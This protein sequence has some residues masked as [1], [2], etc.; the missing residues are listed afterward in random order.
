MFKKFLLWISFFLWYIGSFYM[1]V[2]AWVIPWTIQKVT[3]TESNTC[4]SASHL[5][6]PISASCVNTTCNTYNTALDSTTNCTICGIKTAAVDEVTEVVDASGFVTIPHTAAVP[7]VCFSCADSTFWCDI[8]NTTWSAWWGTSYWDYTLNESYPSFGSYT[9]VPSWYTQLTNDTSET[10]HIKS[11]G[12]N[13]TVATLTWW[14][15]TCGSSNIS[16][17]TGWSNGS[18]NY[19]YSTDNLISSFDQLWAI[20]RS[21]PSDDYTNSECNVDWRIATLDTTGPTVTINGAWASVFNTSDDPRCNITRYRTTTPTDYIP[22]SNSGCEFYKTKNTA[23]TTGNTDFLTWLTIAVSD[24]ESGISKLEIQL[25]SCNYNT[26]TNSLATILVSTSAASWVKAIYKSI[27]LSY[28]DLKTWFWKTRLDQCLVAWKNKLTVYV[29][30]Q[31]R[32]I[33]DG[34]SLSVNNTT[35]V[36]PWYINIDN[37][38]PILKPIDDLSTVHSASYTKWR[39]YTLKGNIQAW[40][41]YNTL[42]SWRVWNTCEPLISTGATCT[43]LPS[44]SH[45]IKPSW[46]DAITGDFTQ[47]KCSLAS[48]YAPTLLECEYGSGTYSPTTPVPPVVPP[49]TTTNICT[50][51]GT[52]PCIVDMWTTPTIPITPLGAGECPVWQWF[53]GTTCIPATKCTISLESITLAT[54]AWVQIWACKNVWATDVW[55]GDPEVNETTTLWQPS[56]SAQWR[57]WNFYQWWNDTPIATNTTITT[58]LALPT[59]WDKWVWSGSTDTTNDWWQWPCDSG[60]HVPTKDEWVAISNAVGSVS[61]I[62]STLKLPYATTIDYEWYRNAWTDFW[63]AT[64]N[65]TYWSA[66]PSPFWTITNHSSAFTYS[67]TDRLW[68]YAFNMFTTDGTNYY[69]NATDLWDTIYRAR[70]FPIRC[71]KWEPAARCAPQPTYVHASYT[72]WTPTNLTA[73]NQLSLPCKYT[74]T[75]GYTGSQCDIPPECNAWQWFNWT[76]CVSATGCTSWLES[77]TVNAYG[78]KQTWACK[79]VWATAVWDGTPENN[80]TSYS[81]WRDSLTSTEYWNWR[82]NFYQWWND[83]PIATIW[84]IA[85][86]SPVPESTNNRVWAG[87]TDTTNVWWQ[88]PCDSGWHVPTRTD[89]WN[90]YN[91]FP[92]HDDFSRILKLPH[93]TTIDYREYRNNL[94][95]GWFFF[96]TN[97]GTYWTGTPTWILTNPPTSQNYSWTDRLWAYVVNMYL[98][99]DTDAIYDDV[100]YQDYGETIFRGRGFPVRCI[101]NWTPSGSTFSCDTQPTYTHAIF[102]IG[103]PT[104]VNQSWVK[105]AVNCWYTCKDRYTGTQCEIL[106]V[107]LPW[108]WFNWTRCISATDCGVSWLESLTVNANGVT[109]TWAC[110][111]LWAT[112]VWDGTPENNVTNY[113]TWATSLTTAEYWNWRW[114]FYQWW[115]NTPIATIWGG[116]V[117]SSPLPDTTNNRVWG[118]SSSIT[119]WWQWPCGSGWHVPTTTDWWNY[120]T[121]FRSTFTGTL[122]LPIATTID[123]QG[124]RNNNA[125]GWFQF[126]TNNGTYWTGTPVNPPLITNPINTQNYSWTDRLRSYALNIFLTG[127]SDTIY[128]ITFQDYGETIYRGRGFPIRCIKD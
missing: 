25:W 104:S 82:W 77:L 123:Y 27:A 78:V 17:R 16:R 1:I 30:D 5:Y 31:A 71:I 28:D 10:C 3:Y 49:T 103:T 125:P 8:W 67:L 106:P 107:C 33:A 105:W 87:S 60:W 21:L 55:N 86:S 32:S 97:N 126:A 81:V 45:W 36:F 34:I 84:G 20:S 128:D 83:T 90:Y 41:R 112:A 114:N 15:T 118:G 50:A 88:W 57:R 64:I 53:D 115:N 43:G 120:R 95:P 48:S 116:I 74:C 121:T 63:F 26:G 14:P 37:L 47:Y 91:Q 22:T 18:C 113:N 6:T 40:E 70:W 2:Y 54:S 65:G 35:T 19:S 12:T 59:V 9:P 66:T 119:D 108:E 85:P 38:E 102:E 44:N 93:A 109:Q 124:Y 46:V 92:L 24:T 79:N 39:N 111:N 13:H 11:N 80:S 73:R 61:N 51:W 68:A 98:T 99:G 110:K 117:A 4:N 72:K 56:I 76:I 89:W 23:I 100:T 96:T 122:R 75:D 94:S 101:K 69:K 62:R 29:D 52:V 42:I 58:W 127:N 7:A